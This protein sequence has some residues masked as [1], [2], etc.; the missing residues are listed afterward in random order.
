[1]KHS[2]STYKAETE[3]ELNEVKILFEQEVSD[4]Y[5]LN[6]GIQYK[7]Y[8]FH[9]PIINTQSNLKKG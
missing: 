6:I 3:L 7:K 5:I 1:M 9:D 2:H 8:T 4:P